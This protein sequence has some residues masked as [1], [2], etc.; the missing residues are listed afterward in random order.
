[1]LYRIPALPVIRV[2][3]VGLIGSTVLPWYS[4][5]SGRALCARLVTPYID[6]AEQ[7]PVLLTR[8]CR[9]QDGT[10]ID[11]WVFRER[12]ATLVAVGI[13]ALLVASRIPHSLERPLLAALPV[14]AMVTIAAI[15]GDQPGLGDE[16][17]DLYFAR[18]GGWVSLACCI[19]IAAG[20][21]LALAGGTR[22]QRGDAPNV[23]GRAIA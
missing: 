7:D 3:A 6:T 22:R 4:A 18:W 8:P 11:L 9:L 16:I 19:G 17:G 14:V 10:L 1:V 21:A 13:L 2:F 23:R 15:L 12:A 20:C 5:Y